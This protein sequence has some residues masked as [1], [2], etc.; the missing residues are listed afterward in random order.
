[1]GRYCIALGERYVIRKPLIYREVMYAMHS[2]TA[3]MVTVLPF[4]TV[5]TVTK[6]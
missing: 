3:N 5:V 4:L 1:M 2:W 6:F